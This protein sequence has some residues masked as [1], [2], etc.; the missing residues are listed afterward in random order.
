MLLPSWQRFTQYS[1]GSRKT[2]S[3]VTVQAIQAM[4]IANIKSHTICVLNSINNQ[5]ANGLKMFGLR[6]VFR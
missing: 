6:I 5:I 2:S 4:G 3:C 1:R